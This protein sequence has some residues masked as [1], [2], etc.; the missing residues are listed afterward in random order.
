[1]A[2]LN[3]IA[4]Y[5]GFYAFVLVTLGKPSENMWMLCA[6]V[7]VASIV[8]KA[9]RER[10][11]QVLSR[12]VTNIIS[13]VVVIVAGFVGL[14]ATGVALGFAWDNKMTVILGIFVL[15]LAL[16]LLKKEPNKGVSQKLVDGLKVG[17]VLAGAFLLFGT[18]LSSCSGGQDGYEPDPMRRINWPG[19][20]QS[21]GSLV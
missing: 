12:S 14:L 3:L 5:L 17:A 16:S 9:F 19:G 10:D 15:A 18:S 7:T 13:V 6:G 1:M 11:V 20:L 21:T 8:I 4:F 2:F